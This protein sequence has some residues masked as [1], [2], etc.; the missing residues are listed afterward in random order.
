M[1]RVKMTLTVDVT[2][3][4]DDDSDFTEDELQQLHSN[5]DFVP[6]YAYDH[7]AFTDDVFTASASF[8]SDV[9]P[10]QEAA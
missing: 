9:T 3:C 2:Y 1:R 10:P 7:G 8:V 4:K 5:L 6:T